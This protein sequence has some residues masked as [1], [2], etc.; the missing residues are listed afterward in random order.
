MRPSFSSCYYI[1]IIIPPHQVVSKFY[2]FEE[3]AERGNTP[4]FLPLF[5]VSAEP[6][7]MQYCMSHKSI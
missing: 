3:K 6:H 4:V 7:E 1:I 5:W 2:T